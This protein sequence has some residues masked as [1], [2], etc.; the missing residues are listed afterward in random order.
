M[1]KCISVLYHA[2]WEEK[3]VI[4]VAT[5]KKNADNIVTNYL[6]KL[7]VAIKDFSYKQQNK[8]S[9]DLYVAVSCLYNERE[10]HFE[11]NNHILNM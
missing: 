7:E 6:T 9:K 3:I 8:N 2:D 4:G 1:K 11:Y 10:H 5:N